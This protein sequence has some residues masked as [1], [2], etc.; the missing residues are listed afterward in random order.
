[1]HIVDYEINETTV[2]DGV[3]LW[4]PESI[5][6]IV[7]P[8]DFPA[9]P[10]KKDAADVI[11][12]PYSMSDPLEIM[13]Y[14]RGGSELLDITIV[15]AKSDGKDNI[16]PECILRYYENVFWTY[17]C[18]STLIPGY[19]YTFDVDCIQNNNNDYKKSKKR[20]PSVITT[21]E[22]LGLTMTA[23]K[24]PTTLISKDG[25][26]RLEINGG[27][28]PFTV[29]FENSDFSTKQISR[30]IISDPVTQS[31]SGIYHITII[32]S[33]GSMITQDIN[34]F[35][36][37]STAI[38]STEIVSQTGCG[39]STTTDLQ[40]TLTKDANADGI[41]AWNRLNHESP[42]TTC[43][44]SRMIAQTSS[45]AN[46]MNI[47]VSEA[48]D[49]QV[50]ICYK[51]EVV[52]VSDNSI[53]VPMQTVHYDVKISTDGSMTYCPDGS[54]IS[55]PIVSISPCVGSMIIKSAAE[56]TFATTK[57]TPFAFDLLDAGIYSFEVA[58]DSLCFVSFDIW[59]KMLT[60]EEC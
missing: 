47:A 28:P 39:L 46:T 27:V 12:L 57:C 40:I 3:Y 23:L 49:W 22:S 5:S 8:L 10:F 2:Y 17:V 26:F 59:S 31:Q 16:Y 20:R 41:G 1:L 42:I 33:T 54:I 50:I 37:A 56:E 29:L 45:A 32:D 6:Y 53:A 24:Q 15:G 34:M 43:S 38:K 48:G 35:P 4:S 19:S 44:D 9:P 11:G 13:I 30:Y 7:Q 21:L 52:A 25:E 55:K 14:I 60:E 18:N 51:G 36:K 58:D